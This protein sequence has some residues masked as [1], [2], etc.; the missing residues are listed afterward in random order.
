MYELMINILN[1]CIFAHHIKL[2]YSIYSYKQKLQ[3]WWF[4]QIILIRNLW[5][6]PTTPDFCCCSDKHFRHCATSHIH[7]N[8]VINIIKYNYVK[9]SY[10]L[11]SF[12]VKYLYIF[13]PTHPNIHFCSVKYSN[14]FI[15]FK[16]LLNIPF[17]SA[18]LNTCNLKMKTN[19]SDVYFEY[20]KYKLVIV[21]DISLK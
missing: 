14:A 11:T 9:S 7:Q 4:S 15:T 2:H 1:P 3:W 17:L 6:K 18:L 5:D 12:K 19:L 13:S 20:F 16:K 21:K 8:S 10:I